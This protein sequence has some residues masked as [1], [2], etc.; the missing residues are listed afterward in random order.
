[1][2]T[3]VY[4]Q[5]GMTAHTSDVVARVVGGEGLRVRIAVP[6]EASATIQKC[7][8]ARLELESKTLFATIDQVSLEVEPASR[9]FLLEGA[10]ELSPESC[11]GG[12]AALAGRSVQTSLEPS[13]E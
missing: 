12:C 9:S 5:P 6:E 8:R 4:F 2:V 13:G 3:G 10:V 11:P 1:V 7:K